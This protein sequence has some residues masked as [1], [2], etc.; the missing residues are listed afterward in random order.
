MALNKRQGVGAAY[1]T[2]AAFISIPGKQLIGWSALIESPGRL[3]AR[4]RLNVA[5]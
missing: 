5:R 3:I 2:G 1:K 4:L